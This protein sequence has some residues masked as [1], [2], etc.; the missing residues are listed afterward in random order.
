MP[1][2][3][4]GPA[5]GG[6]RPGEPCPGRGGETSSPREGGREGLSQDP[7]EMLYPLGNLRPLA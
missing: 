2:R 1:A 7:S 3:S 5:R 6:R 4:P